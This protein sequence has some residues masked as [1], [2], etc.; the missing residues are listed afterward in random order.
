MVARWEGFGGRVKRG[1][2]K[3]YK[4]AVANSPWD[5]KCSAGTTVGIIV[6]TTYCV[7]SV[8]TSGGSFCKL[9]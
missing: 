7:G 6:I 5:E 2:D 8:E 9:Y 1:R 3:K 4:L